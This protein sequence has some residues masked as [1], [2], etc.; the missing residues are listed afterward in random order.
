MSFKPSVSRS[1]SFFRGG[2][3]LELRLRGSLMQLITGVL[4]IIWV[5]TAPVAGA[6]HGRASE[7]NQFLLNQPVNHGI[8]ASGREARKGA[9]R[10][11]LRASGGGTEEWFVIL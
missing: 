1:V 3:C 5:T 9:I 7:S 8:T 10:R 6:A 4:Q 11:F 2:I